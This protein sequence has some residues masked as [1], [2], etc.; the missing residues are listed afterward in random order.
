VLPTRPE[1]HI[2]DDKAVNALRDAIV[3]WGWVF[4]ELDKD[5][6]IDAE[7]EFADSANQ[8]TGG[9]LRFQIK[10]RKKKGA[11]VAVKVSSLKYWMVSPIP[12]FVAKVIVDSGDI[13]VLDVRDYI[14]N[15]KKIDLGAVKAKTL[16]LDFSHA[17]ELEE[18][19]DY[20]A[21]VAVNHQNAVLDLRNYTLYNPVL[22]FISDNRLFRQ[23]GGDIDKMIRWYREEVPDKQLMYEIGHA[24][25]LK[26][27]ITNEPGFLDA[28]RDFVYVDDPENN[29]KNNG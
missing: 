19:K 3:D 8:V 18:W 6:G 15:V 10:G 4:R 7:V 14:E 16:S 17:L 13:F 1:H 20:F 22:E 23:H 26:E 27:R 28:L 24:V 25:Y 9:L 5:Y 2:T 12:V 11:G 29:P 21:E